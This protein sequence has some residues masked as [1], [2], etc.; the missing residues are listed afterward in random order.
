MSGRSHTTSDH[1]LAAH[2]VILQLYALL[3][4]R[5]RFVNFI[6]KRFGQCNATIRLRPQRLQEV[7]W[8]SLNSLTS[9]LRHWWSQIFAECTTAFKSIHNA[10]R[11][12]SAIKKLCDSCKIVKRRG[13]L[14]VV[15]KASPKVSGKSTLMCLPRTQVVLCTIARLVCW[16]CSTNNDRGSTLK[17]APLTNPL[18]PA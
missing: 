3:N 2:E 16:P 12:R 10:M 6:V 5:S 15:C 8:L 7:Y 17:H 11:V 13:K 1:A 4:R 9:S 14:Y 18:T